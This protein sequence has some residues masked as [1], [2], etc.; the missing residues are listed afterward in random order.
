MTFCNYRALLYGF[1]VC[2]KSK[3]ELTPRR[4][5]FI[6]ANSN[7]IVFKRQN[8]RF[9]IDFGCW[10]FTEY[11]TLSALLYSLV[12]SLWLNMIY[13]SYLEIKFQWNTST[14][15]KF[16]LVAFS[17]PFLK[18]LM[19]LYFY[20]TLLWLTCTHHAYIPLPPHDYMSLRTETIFNFY[21]K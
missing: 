20:Y 3:N 2:C 18:M 10:P 17:F 19:Y 4:K 13:S 5:G 14:V 6:R 8:F 1:I 11:K 12:V 7:I 9:K 21:Y 16:S 15:I